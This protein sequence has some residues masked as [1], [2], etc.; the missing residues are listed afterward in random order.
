VALRLSIVGGLSPKHK[1]LFPWSKTF[2][3]KSKARSRQCQN[4]PFGLKQLPLLI[5]RFT[6]IYYQKRF[7]DRSK[8]FMF[9]QW[10]VES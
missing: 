1:S 5:F 7:N 10:P 4:S 6:K 9:G 3:D 2:F 8:G